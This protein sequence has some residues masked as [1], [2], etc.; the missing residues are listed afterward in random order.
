MALDMG[1]LL[2]LRGMIEGASTSVEATGDGAAALTESYARLRSRVR[3]V[4]ED[5]TGDL[6]EFDAAFPE[7]EVVAIADRE[8]PREMAMRGMKYAPQAKRAQ[9]LLKQ[10]AGWVTGLIQEL[11]YEQRSR[12]DSD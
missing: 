1:Q 9:A 7:I 5:S 3:A 8:H 12:Y 10:L 2:R 11:E 6:D 4:M